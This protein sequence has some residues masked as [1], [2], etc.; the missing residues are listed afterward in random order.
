MEI[1][2]IVCLVLIVLAAIAGTVFISLPTKTLDSF[3]K[4]NRQQAGPQKPAPQKP[5]K[6]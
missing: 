4:N 6:P 1:F 5:A 2:L 3:G